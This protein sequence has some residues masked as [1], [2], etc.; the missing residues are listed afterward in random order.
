MD[1]SQ[2]Y[3]SLIKN[4]IKTVEG[5]KM[6]PTWLHLKEG[7]VLQINCKGEESFNV[8]IV[9]INYYPKSLDNPLVSY[10]E[11]ET[12]AKTLPHV[13]TIEDGCR[14]YL[15]WSTLEEIKALGFMG[16]HFERI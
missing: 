2:P 15:Q 6:S 12:L 16:I 5:R 9:K 11:T 10:L 8:R 1:I 3:F 13:S 4:G 7:D 14:I